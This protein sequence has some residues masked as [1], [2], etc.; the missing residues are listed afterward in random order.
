MSQLATTARA[1]TNFLQL[2]GRLA[3]V[4]LREGVDTVRVHVTFFFVGTLL[5]LFGYVTIL[6]SLVAL[7]AR[8]FDFGWEIATLCVAV[9][10]LGIGVWCIFRAMKR[11]SDKPLFEETT[12]VLEKDQ[13][14]IRTHLGSNGTSH[15]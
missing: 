3:A 11:L 7:L 5:A 6:F 15:S 1:A 14:W 4:E 9:P 12:Q 13:E 2:R 8:R 10:H